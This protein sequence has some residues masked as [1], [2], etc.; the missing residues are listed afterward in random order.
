MKRPL[1]SIIIPVFNAEKSIGGLVAHVLEQA[2]ADFELILINDGSEDDSLA[3]IEKFEKE[4]PRVQVFSQTN[5]GQSSARNV[6]ISR[7]RG[8]YIIFL[9]A[10]DDIEPTMIEKLSGRM[11]ETRVDLVVCQMRQNFIKNDRIV[12][13]T[14]VYAAPLP[15][16][17]SGEDFRTYVV[18]LLG[19]NGRLYHPANKIYRTDL[20]KKHGVKF[21]EGLN[22]GEDL[23]FNLHYLA[24]VR[25]INFLDEPLYHYNLDVVNGTF[26]KSSLIYENRLKN[27]RE[28]LKFA[29]KN[30]SPEL[31]DLL[32][33]IKYYWFYSFVLALCASDLS[34]HESVAR[35]SEALAIDPLP[36]P[37]ARQHIGRSK[38]R[39]EKVLY[40]LRHR[41]GTIY[42]TVRTLNFFKNQRLFA[43][44]WRKLTNKLLR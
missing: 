27:Y 20:I 38:A 18:R 14:I 3:I 4:D 41:P 33:W 6:G 36:R 1:L 31:V 39:I 29:G 21:Q 40:S 13:S 11:I 42:R 5:H 16:H 30:P 24:H 44:T 8:K 15:E 9:D 23:T 17:R 32:G 12:S 37:G 2:M 26:G 22:F 34:K 43:T 10:D 35:L 28:I 7:A 25:T 19:I